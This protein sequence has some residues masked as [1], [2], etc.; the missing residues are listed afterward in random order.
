MAWRGRFDP[1]T[2]SDG[3]DDFRRATDEVSADV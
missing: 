3:D 1:Q 2:T